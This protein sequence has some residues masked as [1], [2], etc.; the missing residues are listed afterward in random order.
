MEGTV[1]SDAGAQLRDGVKTINK[2]GACSEVTWP[3]NISKFT[4]KPSK[5]A[6]DEALSNVALQYESLDGTSITNL[7]KALVSGFPFVFGFT[8]YESFESQAVATSGVVPMPSKNESCLG[9]HAVL[10]VGYDDSKNCVLVRN[11]WGVGW[12]LQGYFWMPYA[13]I[14][15]P[16]LAS[17]FWVIQSIK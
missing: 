13:Y 15:N 10:C 16:N 8:V 11:S 2:Y 12:G 1:K 6:Y 14:T 9:G 17:D 5:A 7:K 4:V 3:Y